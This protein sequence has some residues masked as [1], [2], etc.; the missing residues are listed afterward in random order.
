[1]NKRVIVTGAKM[2]HYIIPQ[3]PSAAIIRST[4]LPGWNNGEEHFRERTAVVGGNPAT[5]HRQIGWLKNNTTPAV[6]QSNQLA[7]DIG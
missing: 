3:S 2:D 5:G 4:Y 1:L 6:P 7:G